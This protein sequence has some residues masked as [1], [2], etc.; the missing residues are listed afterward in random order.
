MIEDGHQLI[1]LN[2]IQM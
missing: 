2:A 1:Q